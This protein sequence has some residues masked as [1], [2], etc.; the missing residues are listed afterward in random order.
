MKVNERDSDRKKS[1]NL[2][3]DLGAVT[4]DRYRDMYHS[5]SQDRGWTAH[6]AVLQMPASGR[7]AAPPIQPLHRWNLL[8]SG[9][10]AANWEGMAWGPMTGDGRAS[11][12]MVNDDGFSSLQRNWLSVLAPVHRPGCGPDQFAF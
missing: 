2:V 9:L 1:C 4:F 10:P 8:S 3:D 11:L 5:V 12:V 7:A 6:L